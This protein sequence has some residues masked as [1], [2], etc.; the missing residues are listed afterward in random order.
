MQERRTEHGTEIM[1]F[2][3]RNYTE[4]IQG[5]WH[6][7][8]K[9]WSMVASQQLL[10]VA[11]QLSSLSSA[12]YPWKIFRDVFTLEPVNCFT[13]KHREAKLPASRNANESAWLRETTV[14][15]YYTHHG[16]LL[17]SGTLCILLPFCV[18]FRVPAFRL[19]QLPVNRKGRE[20][21]KTRGCQLSQENDKDSNVSIYSILLVHQ[22]S[23]YHISS[24]CLYLKIWFLI[25]AWL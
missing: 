8:T 24:C 18:P 3:T 25:C 17:I 11:A 1:W 5:V 23:H 21:S 13:L 15:Y 14:H 9:S 6:K 12:A 19:S 20:T 7:V 22:A 16:V 4:M 10:C 2:H